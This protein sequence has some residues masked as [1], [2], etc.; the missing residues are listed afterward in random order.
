M[1]QGGRDRTKKTCLEESRVAHLRLRDFGTD[2]DEAMRPAIVE[3]LLGPVSFGSHVRQSGCRKCV[4]WSSRLGYF[5][6]LILVLFN[7]TTFY[8]QWS[9]Y[10]S[11]RSTP[12]KHNL[13]FALLSFLLACVVRRNVV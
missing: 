7:C 3:Q 5:R 1:K 10:L 2:N 6:I 4:Y 11:I 12:L 8:K 9:A 13:L